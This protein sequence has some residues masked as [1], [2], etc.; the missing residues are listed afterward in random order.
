[1]SVGIDD[2][3]AYIPALSL[4]IQALAEARDIEYPKLNKGLGLTAM[5]LPDRNEDTATL[6]ANAVLSLIHRNQLDPMS[7][8]RIYMGTESSFDGSKPMAS[9]V[10]QMLNAQLEERYGKDCFLHCDVVDLTF[11]CIGAVDALQ[12]TMDWVIAGDD[13]KGI[14][15][16]SDI[17]WYDLGSTGEYTQGAGAVAMLVSKNPRLLGIDPDWGVATDAVYDFFKPLRKLPKANL[18]D[19]I[20]AAQGLNGNTSEQVYGQLMDAEDSIWSVDRNPNFMLHSDTP[21]FDGP[22]SNQC[23]QERIG[24]ALRHF[25][26]QKDHFSLLEDWDRMIFHLPYAYQA[27]RMFTALYLEE[28]VSNGNLSDLETNLGQTIP[29]ANDYEGEAAY[30]KAKSQFLRALSKSDAYKNFVAE[31]IEKGERASSLVG[32]LYTGSI[33]LSL[34]SSLE[35]DLLASADQLEGQKL[36][37]FAYGSG[38]KSKVFQ[39]EVQEG[40]MEVIRQ[41]QL[42]ERLENRQAISF[43]EYEALRQVGSMQPVATPKGVFHLVEVDEREGDT[44]GTRSYAFAEIKA[45]LATA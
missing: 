31:R 40:A 13:R 7:I 20:V 8:G 1:M 45:E 28:Y 42:M 30:Q 43:E 9:Y 34:M 16:A 32:N 44:Y 23:Y 29:Q 21:V 25:A 22:Y 6:A 41:W 27:R 4:P 14:V 35:A 5:S 37:F 26:A 19:E 36:G 11:A 15:V 17:A 33:W 10:L 38:S 2:M 24:Q 12:N 3:A 18:V 39:G